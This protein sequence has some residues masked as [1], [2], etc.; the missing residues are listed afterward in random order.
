MPNRSQMGVRMLRIAVDPGADDMKD[1]SFVVSIKSTRPVVLGVGQVVDRPADPTRGREPLALMADATRLALVDAGGAT[2][3]A[4]DTL[5]VV[6]NVFHDY[7][8]TA[9]ML[10]ARLEAHPRRTLLS[11][12]GGNTPVALFS[13]LCDEIAAGR[14][15]VAVMVGAEAVA[16]LRACQKRGTDPGWTA[17]APSGPARWGDDRDGSHPLERAHGAFLPTVTFALVENAFRA[18][19]GQ[20]IAA[21]RAELGAFAARCTAVAAGN[22]YAW[23]P[24]AVDAATLATPTPDNRIIAFPYPKRMN[25]IMSVNQGAA[26]VVASEAAGDRLGLRREGRVWPRAAVDV[27]E[28][29]FMIERRDFHSLPGVQAAGAALL[30]TIGTPIDEIDVLDLYSCFPIAPRLVAHMLGLPPDLDRPLT[31]AG[32]LPWFGGPGN[33]YSTHALAAV[34]ERLRDGRGSTALV[35][36]LGMMLSKHALVSL[37]TAPDAE[38]RRVDAAPLRRLVSA[39]PSPP[40]VAAPSGAATIETY[41]VTHGRN[42]DPEGGVVMGRTDDDGRFI[43]VLPADRDLL[44]ALEREEGVGLRGT[45]RTADGRNVF[46]PA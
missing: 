44:S 30:E 16:T 19:R 35:H 14:A 23:F 13:H 43:A 5:A 20:S 32:G 2:A 21:Q 7:G 17:P 33:N 25:A 46:A 41:T 3:D 12:W 38:W 1:V 8:D 42:G 15:E 24:E 31:A 28:Q 22:P 4:V 10:A 18:A 39:L 27:T 11:T 26:I 6:T 36:A 45:V 29:W 34:V 40:V 37:A 9:R